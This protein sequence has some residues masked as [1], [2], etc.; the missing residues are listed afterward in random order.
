MPR[1][2]IAFAR[3]AQESN[4]LSPVE[5]DLDDFKRTHLLYGD[6]VLRA[7]QPDQRE[8]QGFIK[9]A[10]LSGFVK[11]TTQYRNEIEILPIYS[12]WAVPGGPLSRQVFG[13]FVDRLIEELRRQAPIDGVFLSLHGSLCVRGIEDPEGFMIQ[14][15]RRA[16]G[17]DVPI[18]ATLDLHAN[19]TPHK[20]D[21]NTLLCAYRT[22]PHRDHYQ[23]GQRA[24]DLLCRTVLG[25]TRPTIAWRTLPMVL[26]GG[27]TMDFLNPMRPIY[28]WMRR[29]EKDPRVLYM[30]LLNCHLWIDHERM[31]WATHVITDGDQQLAEDLAEQLADKAWEV[32]HQQPPE[33]PSASEAI[34][35]ARDAR[36]ARRLGTVC[37]SD[38]SDMVGA[39]GTGE[40]TALLRAFLEEGTDLR[41]L[42]PVRDPIVVDQLWQ[43]Q[44][45]EDVCVTVGGRLDPARNTPIEI[46][47]KLRVNRDVFACGRVSVIDVGKL[48]L[49]ITE[50]AAMVMQPKF[51]RTLGLSPWNADVVVVKSLFPFRLYFALHN[52]K[53]IY[54]KTNGITDF[55]AGLRETRFDGPVWPKD[56]VEDWRPTD[57]RRRGLGD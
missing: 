21:G 25:R 35:Q 4:A 49:A 5:S 44:P 30:S 9:N 57:R 19:I 10:E 8:V 33:F 41:T 53:T 42:L 29:M 54:A 20:T 46:R 27:T 24:G 55:D 39:G 36:L 38:A 50:G 14:E 2:R 7:C 12:A 22:N 15:V 17:Q 52:R 11:A 18:A 16:L 37:M 51:Y 31:G 26:G 48:S 34:R 23:V 56:L 43:R 45:G 6:E 28:Q 40:N 32:R 1:K 13:D 47:G 3:L